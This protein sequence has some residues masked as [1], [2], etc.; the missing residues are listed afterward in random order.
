MRI[1][2]SDYDGTLYRN[3]LIL[4]KDIEAISEWRK[5]GNK[6]G[7][8]TGRDLSL[9]TYDINK[10]GIPFDFLVCDNGAVLYDERLNMLQCISIPD[11][12]IRELLLHPSALAST[13]YQFC[14]E[15]KLKLYIRSEKSIFRKISAP[16]SEVSFEESLE[17]KNIQQISFG[18]TS[19]EEY[20]KHSDRLTVVFKDKLSLNFNTVYIDINKDGVNKLSGIK[21]LISIKGW[22]SEGLIAIGD[23]ENDLPMIRHFGGFSIAGAKN[24]IIN[25][26]SGEF[27]SVGDMLTNYLQN[28]I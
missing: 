16:F 4:P 26:A 8:A 5:A 18:Y 3:N 2:V 25:E 12:M 28:S 13:H 27:K 6:F 7:F 14:I 23:G 24:N 19:E 22:P 11:G 17:L 9:I 1:A 20:K 15:G 10:W 21:N